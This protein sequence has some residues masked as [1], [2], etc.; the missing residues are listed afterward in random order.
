MFVSIRF[1]DWEA[2]K[3]LREWGSTLLVT[4]GIHY[5]L[6]WEWRIDS[7]FQRDCFAY[8]VCRWS[9]ESFIQ[10]HHSNRIKWLV[11]CHIQLNFFL[12]LPCL[13]MGE[14][15][16]PSGSLTYY[17]AIA[18]RWTLERGFFSIKRLMEGSHGAWLVWVV[19]SFFVTLP[20]GKL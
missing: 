5:L 2:E 10:L 16:F 4:L 14:L 3:W 13:Q 18:M 15:V 11:G 6:I 12:A 7:C 20:A 9:G 17:A 1:G 8:Q 19:S